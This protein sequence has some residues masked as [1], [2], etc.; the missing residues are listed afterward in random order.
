M[1]SALHIHVVCLLVYAV[2]Q[3]YQA[4]SAFSAVFIEYKHHF[5][6]KIK[7]LTAFH[8]LG[9][10][11]SSVLLIF[12][13]IKL[14]VKFIASALPYLI[15]KVGFF[16][17]HLRKAYDITIG[18]EETR[19]SYCDPSRLLRFYQHISL[20][21]KKKTILSPAFDLSIQNFTVHLVTTIIQS[22]LLMKI[23][24]ASKGEQTNQRE[25]ESE[26]CQEKV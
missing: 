7:F 3:F 26:A 18:C 12:G 11:S 1:I 6:L 24:R 13:S 8:I 10:L 2:F 4:Y 9:M 16:F 25:I 21:R 23:L 17:W 22:C 19:D 5:E 15:Y 20:F 14:K